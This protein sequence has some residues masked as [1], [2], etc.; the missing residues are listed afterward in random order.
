[1]QASE[2][3]NNGLKRKRE[4]SSALLDELLN[5]CENPKELLGGDGL[6]HQLKGALIERILGAELEHHLGYAKHDPAGRGSGNSR[7]GA[8]AKT[9]HTESGSVEVKIPRDRT[10]TFEPALIPKHSRR[11]E[12]FDDKVLSLYARGMSMRDIQSHLG[13]LY[14][15]EVSPELISRVTDVVLADLKEW[16]SRPLLALYPVLYLD[17][18]FVSVRDNGQVSKKAIYVALGVE[19]SGHRDVLGLWMEQSEGAKFWMQ[20]LTDLRNRGVEDIFFVCCDGLS[21]FPKA[22]EAVFPKSIVQTCIVH[23]IR[24]S[25]RYVRDADRK[26]IVR[27]L[28][29]IYTA[30]NGAAA[31]EA[32]SAFEKKQGGKYPSIGKLWRS[33]WKEVVPFLAFPRE[34]RRVLYTTNAI[35]SLNFQ[36]RKVLRTKGLFPND[37]AALKLC[38]VAIQR[39]KSRWSPSPVWRQAM[40]QFAI[41]FGERFLIEI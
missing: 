25:L 28:K 16:Q 24:A 37:E 1:M 30:E 15:T 17:A 31:E 19:P 9:V 40:S 20:V 34:V 32:L 4:F 23:M 10:G 12:G 8:T 29:E 21:G 14:G 38:F 41:M 2:K 27:E 11:L 33:R 7:N 3:E 6:L 35:E 13:E 18:L 26:E 22:I 36:L 5:S 39:A